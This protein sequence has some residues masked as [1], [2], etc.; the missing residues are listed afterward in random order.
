MRLKLERPCLYSSRLLKYL[1]DIKAYAAA[2][3]LLPLFYIYFA[4]TARRR[5]APVAGARTLLLRAS[6]RAVFSAE[7]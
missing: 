1:R 2:L 4:V 3:Y 7:R 6:M 5:A